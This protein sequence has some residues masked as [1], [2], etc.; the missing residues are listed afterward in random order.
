MEYLQHHRKNLVPS[1]L[2]IQPQPDWD[3]PRSPQD[4]Y[5]KWIFCL[6]LISDLVDQ[7]MCSYP[8]ILGLNIPFG[9]Y[10]K[11]RSKS[12]PGRR[13]WWLDVCVSSSRRGIKPKA[14][15]PVF[16][17]VRFI[18]SIPSFARTNSIRI[19]YA[20]GKNDVSRFAIGR[21][22]CCQMDQWISEKIPWATRSP[23]GC[24]P[25]TANPF[26]TEQWILRIV[27]S[28]PAFTVRSGF[29]QT[30]VDNIQWWIELWNVQ[31][32]CIYE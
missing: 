17:I 4:I 8:A 2:S 28:A 14:G 7:M 20:N 10:Y 32:P 23:G 25:L 3:I 27:W 26:N 15:L 11:D 9:K 22:V 24:L 13:H 21:H 19:G 1:G 16:T 5:F 12:L 31:F 18:W 29:E 30:T 6:T